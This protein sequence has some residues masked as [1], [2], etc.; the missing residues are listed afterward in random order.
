MMPNP[1]KTVRGSHLS[2]DKWPAHRHIEQVREQ[3]L[4]TPNPQPQQR[5][6]HP[7]FVLYHAEPAC[8]AAVDTLQ[9]CT[10]GD[11][12]A[13]KDKQLTVKFHSSELDRLRAAAAER[14]LPVS[15][16]VR[17]ALRAAGVPIAA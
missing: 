12:M 6:H 17:E 9:W 13:K 5:V 10:P 1:S 8:L 4:R 16:V 11:S 3:V 7:R 14:Q 15:V 2:R